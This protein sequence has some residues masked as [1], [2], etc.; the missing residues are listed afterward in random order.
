MWRVLSLRC[1]QVGERFRARRYPFRYIDKNVEGNFEARSFFLS[2]VLRCMETA[3]SLCHTFGTQ[4][5]VSF[6]QGALETA[7]WIRQLLWI[8]LHF[9]N[10][11][12]MR[13]NVQNYLLYKCFTHF[14]PLKMCDYV[15]HI[16]FHS[17]SLKKFIC[18]NYLKF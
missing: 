2:V 15:A 1:W 5:A 6:D 10:A 7:T 4:S 9:L 12:L 3:S 13:S 11:I 17:F 18:K 16:T 8:C 14:F